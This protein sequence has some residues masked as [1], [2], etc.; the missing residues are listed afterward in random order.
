M[1]KRREVRSIFPKNAVS[2]IIVFLIL[3]LS[4]LPIGKVVAS[5]LFQTGPYE[6]DVLLIA[7]P[8]PSYIEQN[9]VLTVSVTPRDSSAGTASG[10]VEIRS[11]GEEVCDL[12]LD[13]LGQASCH[14]VFNEPG[15]IPFQA[16][17]L[18][19]NPIL[20]GASNT[21]N[22]TVLNKH[23]PIM[24]VIQDDPDPSILNRDIYANV[25]VS[26]EGPI[27]SGSL[28]VYRSDTTCLS[29]DSANAVDQC[30]A[31]LNVSG[32]GGCALP[33]TQEGV[34]SICS[35]YSGDYAHYPAISTAEHHYVS[36]SNTFT[37][38][39]SI[40]PEPSLA[41]ELLLV[42]FTVTSPDG[43]PS[44]GLVEITGPDGN[45]M[46]PV[47]VGECTIRINQAHLQPVYASYSGE[48]GGQIELE[49]SVSDVVMHRVNVAATDIRLDK[50]TVNAYLGKNTRVAT[51]TALDANIDESH[52]FVLI[53]G[54][55]AD[56]NDLF[57]ID[58]NQLVARGNLPVS[59]GIVKFRVM[60]ID[61]A[62]LTFEKV[63]S[64]RVV[65][66]SP[67]LP[68]TGFAAGQITKV[69]DQHVPYQGTDVTLSI[70]K[71]GISIP[72]VGIPYDDNS[73]NTDWLSNQAGWLNGT[74]FPGWQGNA[75]LAAHNYLADGTAGPFIGLERLQWGDIIEVT[76][77]GST[78]VYE[79]R[80]V[81]KV[82][83]DDLSVLSHQDEPWLT[84]VTCKSFSEKTQKYRWRI[85]VQA[86]LVDVK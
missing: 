56:Q 37:T 84:L 43:V 7:N 55:G 25:R 23:H 67:E 2:R 6:V 72:V 62:G 81:K 20:P 50:D 70:P 45:C 5:E 35:T 69:P 11:A 66:N 18:G 64:L 4:L 14:L 78:S 32:E 41:G 76:A 83:P 60:T 46:A 57:W 33:L 8:S 86:V 10:R 74:A 19:I 3:A 12:E 26:S 65:D 54:T 31:A 1:R 63:L 27:P 22:H 49:P 73:W 28:I 29:P 40:S 13:S 85:I 58:G 48:I 51:L 9:I 61:P 30:S 47:N 38:I 44:T 21:I 17:Y 80:D 39:T 52:S 75:V 15:V 34:V 36:N 71:L 16:F 42:Q 68:A 53:D 24:E 77:F 82:K 79:V 59:P